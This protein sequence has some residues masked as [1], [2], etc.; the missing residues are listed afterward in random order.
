MV[1]LN[2]IIARELLSTPPAQEF[3]E[4]SSK[5]ANSKGSK[6]SNGSQGSDQANLI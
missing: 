5:S 1:D 3:L 6:G 4:Q 2:N